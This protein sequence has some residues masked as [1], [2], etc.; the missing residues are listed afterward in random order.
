M[1]SW[2]HKLL[3]VTNIKITWSLIANLLSVWSHSNRAPHLVIGSIMSMKCIWFS[4]C[5]LTSKTWKDRHSVDLLGCQNM[6]TSKTASMI[7]MQFQ[8]AS[9]HVVQKRLCPLKKLLA[10][11]D[12]FILSSSHCVPV[13][14]RAPTVPSSEQTVNSLEIVQ[15]FSRTQRSRAWTPADSSLPKYYSSL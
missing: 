8:T 14:L 10:L 2:N 6:P 1:F 7:A 4:A 15:M 13:S 5:C 9:L 3:I 11:T 12:L